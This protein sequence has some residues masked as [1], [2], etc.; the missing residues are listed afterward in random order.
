MTC[1]H[2]VNYEKNRRNNMKQ[3]G[4]NS[5]HLK[6]VYRPTKQMKSEFITWA[7]ERIL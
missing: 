1:K 3:S 6:Y 7:K 2:K 4:V 5:K